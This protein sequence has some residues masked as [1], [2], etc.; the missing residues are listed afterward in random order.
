MRRVTC[1]GL[2]RSGHPAPV[3]LAAWPVWALA[4]GFRGVHAA[5]RASELFDRLRGLRGR[6][7][8]GL[9][10]RGAC[11]GRASELFDWLRGL[12]DAHELAHLCDVYTYTT[13]IAQC[14]SHQQLRKALE[15][16]A[17]MRGHGIQCNVHTYSALMNV[18]IKARLGPAWQ[19]GLLISPSC[20]YLPE[21][22]SAA[23]AAGPCSDARHAVLGLTGNSTLCWGS[24]LRGWA[25]P[26]AFGVATTC[27]RRA[28]RANVVTCDRRTSWSWRWT[29]TDSCCA[30]AARPTW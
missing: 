3:Q 27:V 28:E 22:P 18:C 14:G 9:F 5:G 15:L 8:G 7:R 2:R 1:P 30:R 16:V 24:M 29:C 26:D 23:A 11:R 25:C 21:G 4:R 10:L 13:I 6:L 19:R 20:L 17:E 12:P